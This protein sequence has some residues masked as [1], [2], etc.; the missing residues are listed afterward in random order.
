[1]T[2]GPIA[3]FCLSKGHIYRDKFANLLETLSLLNTSTL[4]AV[5]WLA[6]TT[7]YK[8]W[9]HF[10]EYATYISVA[11]TIMTCII[12]ILYQVFRS[13]ENKVKQQ[14]KQDKKKYHGSIS[15]EP[16]VLPAP[17]STVVE[18]DKC[19]QLKEPLL[20]SN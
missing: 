12:V 2:V 10:E 4:F 3:I 8:G 11:V 16:T 6:T 13:V 9:Q 20:D 19:S 18:L 1:M 14:M 15:A 7:G 17:T 5:C